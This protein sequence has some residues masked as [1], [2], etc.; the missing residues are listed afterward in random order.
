MAAALGIVQGLDAFGYDHDQCCPDQN[1]SAEGGDE[2]ELAR[3]KG[4][5]EW[6]DAGKKGPVNVFSIS[7]RV[8]YEL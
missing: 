7:S 3:G 4:E 1:P 8:D 5:G 2:T 6:E